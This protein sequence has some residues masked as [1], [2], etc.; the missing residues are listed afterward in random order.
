MK[1]TS[2]I[3]IFQAGRHADQSGTTLEITEADLERTVAAYD[4]ARWQAP[5]VIG[6][7]RHDAPAWGWVASLELRQG[8]LLANLEEVSPRVVELVTA[9]QY[10]NVS[11]SFYTPQAACNPVPGV[12]YLRHVGL[13]GAQPPAVKGLPQVSFQE[14]ALET[15]LAMGEEMATTMHLFMENQMTETDEKRDL[16]QQRELLAA[17]EAELAA[18][19]RRFEEQAREIAQREEVVKKSQNDQQRAKTT[20]FVDALIAEGK[21]LPRFR[22]GLLA[23]MTFLAESGVVAFAET[24]GQMGFLKAF[25]TDL[26]PRVDYAERTP[27]TR[28]GPDS[29]R[30][31]LPDGY[32]AD[33][34]GLEMHGKILSYANS[35]QTDYL[36]AALAVSA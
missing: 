9:G 19:A 12:F 11:A 18:Q 1:T 26:P 24:Q 33:P 5:L 21:I 22:D 6:H 15:A 2:H 35:H 3:A 14:P 23:F 17:R 28:G 20:E 4:P 25:L 7:P 29:I 16:A 13:L 27:S 32:T 10:R 31:Q 34:A 8:T 36:T 30:F